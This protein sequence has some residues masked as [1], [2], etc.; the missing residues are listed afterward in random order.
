MECFM[1]PKEGKLKP[2][3]GGVGSMLKSFG[4]S[5]NFAIYGIFVKYYP[6]KLNSAQLDELNKLGPVM[7]FMPEKE[8]TPKV[9][10][11]YNLMLHNGYSN[12][13]PKKR[14]QKEILFRKLKEFIRPSPFPT[15][16]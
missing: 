5:G 10:S 1:V 6:E 9:Y 2:A 7:F 13:G 11:D 3:L 4:V 8:V 15:G 12:F 16:F 14:F